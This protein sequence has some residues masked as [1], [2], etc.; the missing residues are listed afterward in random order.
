[1]TLSQHEIPF[2]PERTS[3][4]NSEEPKRFRAAWPDA[5]KVRVE[6]VK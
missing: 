2:S 6:R 3:T 4:W 1:M 5:G